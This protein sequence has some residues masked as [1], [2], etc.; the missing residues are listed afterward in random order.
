MET[1]GVSEH[2]PESP[3]PKPRFIFS[4]RFVTSPLQKVS[5]GNN[6]LLLPPSH[7]DFFQELSG[8]RFGPHLSKEVSWQIERPRSLLIRKSSLSAHDALSDLEPAAQRRVLEYVSGMLGLPF[9]SGGDERRSAPDNQ[10]I[11]RLL[12]RRLGIAKPKITRASAPLRSNGLRERSRCVDSFS[13]FSLGADEIDLVAKKLPG[14]NKKER[15]HSVLLLKS[16]SPHT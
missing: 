2:G 3:D 12:R 4:R 11:F 10:N 9:P 15:M 5:P 13:F 1:S 7:I 14:N 8:M 6:D 16:G